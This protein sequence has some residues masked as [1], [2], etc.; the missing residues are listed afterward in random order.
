MKSCIVF[1][2]AI[3]EYVGKMKSKIPILLILGLLAI[4]SLLPT[5]IS[6]CEAQTGPIRTTYDFDTGLPT[7]LPGQAAPVNQT[8]AGIMAMFTSPINL[9]AYSIQTQTAVG[10]VLSN[11]SG[12][13]LYP[14]D[15]LRN[16]LV[17]NFNEKLTNITLTFATVE[18]HGGTAD[19]A[20]TL[21]LTAYLDS[22]QS[23]PVG[24]ANATG[25]F[26]ASNWPQ[27]TL[28]FYSTAP[29]NIVRIELPD[30]TSRAP[31]FLVDNLII[32]TVDNPTIPELSLLALLLLAGFSLTLLIFLR[33][34]LNPQV[35]RWSTTMN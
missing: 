30:P 4:A 6:F 14:N 1:I 9:A 12:N 29:F 8:S 7:L 27:G 2:V 21:R 32:T 22:A 23:T 10:V 34:N 15:N 5:F 35:K 18:L 16:A 17:I 25:E 20:S 24:T 31:S 26:S 28:S 13:F 3:E 11:F 19:I 33:R